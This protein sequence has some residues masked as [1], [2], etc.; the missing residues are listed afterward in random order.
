[1]PNDI[2]NNFLKSEFHFLKYTY[3]DHFETQVYFKYVAS[4][5]NCA[6]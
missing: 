3:N 6:L 2:Q 1:M 4:K 5:F